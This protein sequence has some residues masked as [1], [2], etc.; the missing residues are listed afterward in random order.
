MP[1]DRK[2]TAPLLTVKNLAIDFNTPQ[3][4]LHAVRDLSLDVYPQQLLALVGESGSGKSVTAHAIL[5]LLP[6]NGQVTGG[7]ICYKGNSLL[8]MDEDEMRQLRGKGIAII[9]Q[10]PGRSFDPLYPISR[11][12]QETIRAHNSTASK[13]EIYNQSLALL[14][15]V[16][17]VNPQQR[18]VNYPHQFSGG[19]LQRINIALA[20][21]SDPQLLIADEP[22][23]ALD[24]TIQAEIIALLSRLQL[25]R[26]LAILFISHDI[27]LVGNIADEIAIMYA[28]RILEYGSCKTLFQHPHHPYSAALLRSAITIGQH[29]SRQTLQAIPG[30]VPDP[31]HQDSGCPFA[32]R[33]PLVEELCR[34][35]LPAW[36]SE[37]TNHRCRLSGSKV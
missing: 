16:G 32:P 1:P 13:E 7:D 35:A 22:T 20:L 17:I 11:V 34:R 25:E 8:A 24:L 36:Q 27:A 18:I 19:Q 23:T 30:T 26:G 2:A 15:E 12:F 33:C 28:G 10:E 29:H 21:A 37:K 4:I 9:F 31:Y 5:R 3:G 14:G 6:R